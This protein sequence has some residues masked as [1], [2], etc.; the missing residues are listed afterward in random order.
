MTDW[1][2]RHPEVGNNEVLI[3]NY[4]SHTYK[5][6]SYK[7]K[8]KGTRAYD[9]DGLDITHMGFICRRR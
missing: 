4:A 9:I 7:T 8:R 5:D 2:H 3:G 6:I 1:R